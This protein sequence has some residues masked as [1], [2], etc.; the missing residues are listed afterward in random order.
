VLYGLRASSLDEEGVLRCRRI[1][2]MP[3]FARQNRALSTLVL[4]G[5]EDGEQ[6]L[7]QLLLYRVILT[8]STGTKECARA[9][10]NGHFDGQLRRSFAE[11]GRAPGHCG[12]LLS[13]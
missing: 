3:D 8:S 9:L 13:G 10:R 12:Y 11:G 6:S 4:A 7:H 2:M 1:R 5:R